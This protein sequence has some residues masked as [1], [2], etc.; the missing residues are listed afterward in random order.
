MRVSWNMVWCQDKRGL[1]G[2][3]TGFYTSDVLA[4]GW[5]R[6]NSG[7]YMQRN[8]TFACQKVAHRGGAALAPE[9]TMA[10]FRH[11]PM[12]SVDA[13][14]LD[15]QMSRD[16]HVIVFHDETVERLTHGRG[17][18]LD[19]DLAYLR[20]L[21]VAAHF[22][23]GWPEPQRIPALTEVLAFAR[24]ARLQMYIEVKPGLREGVYVRYPGIAEAVV[25]DVLAAG[26]LDQVLIMSFDW[27]VLPH[28]KTLAPGAT[29]CTLV[30]EDVW[31]PHARAAL[32]E[33]VTR[34]RANG[35]EWVNI[36]YEL[37]TPEMPDFFH[38]HG[39]RLGVWT[40]NDAAGLQRLAD[41]GV[42]SL[43]TDRPDLF[44]APA[45]SDSVVA[46]D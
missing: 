40:V 46:G 5:T 31:N 20:G 27:E 18:I 10:A 45:S 9:N 43:T 1:F 13:I 23:G 19:L 24:Q 34:V 26:M 17:N 14:E 29:T 21:D 3:A 38:A 39:L 8:S 15:V 36:D 42:D 25:K 35:C 22:S 4:S 6:K 32:A 37:F 16:G 44:A 30:S 28:I 2:N 33:L 7:C 12:F 41:A 11:A